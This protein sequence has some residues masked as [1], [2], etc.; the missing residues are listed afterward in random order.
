MSQPSGSARS[1][2]SLSSCR[3]GAQCTLLPRLLLMPF[4]GG[5][6]DC[7]VNRRH[8]EKPDES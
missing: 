4:A 8:W 6:N 7:A 3:D 5:I 1:L 2:V